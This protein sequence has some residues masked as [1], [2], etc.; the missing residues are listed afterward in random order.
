MD[1][2]N[3]IAAFCNAVTCQPVVL[4]LDRVFGLAIRQ[5][6]VVPTFMS[7]LA[8]LDKLFDAVHKVVCAALDE[9][10]TH[11][12]IHAKLVKEKADLIQNTNIACSEFNANKTV[13]SC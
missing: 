12:M 10:V 6:V 2:A 13:L 7:F 3:V 11:N 9:Q 5:V 4:I 1:F 8:N